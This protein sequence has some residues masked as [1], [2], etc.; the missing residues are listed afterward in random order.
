MNNYLSSINF[1]GGTGTVTISFNLVDDINPDSLLQNVTYTGWPKSRQD[2]RY[3]THWLSK[4]QNSV[5]D[6]EDFF[7]K[8][9]DFGM[10]H[11]ILHKKEGLKVDAKFHTAFYHDRNSYFI[12]GWKIHRQ[13]VFDGNH[14]HSI[15]GGYKTICCSQ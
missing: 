9:G 3:L 15:F 5:G 1:L 14:F 8:I 4:I 6:F 10:G 12:K 11:S 13:I 7:E 2:I